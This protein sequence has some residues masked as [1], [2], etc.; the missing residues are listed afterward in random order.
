MTFS[1]KISIHALLAEGDADILAGYDY[2]LEIS[3]HA[4]LAEGDLLPRV[5]SGPG[6]AI[7]IHALLAEGDSKSVQ[8]PLSLLHQNIK[9]FLL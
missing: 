4:L 3:I 9:N 1:G 7:S 5:Q 2:E 6:A 8:K